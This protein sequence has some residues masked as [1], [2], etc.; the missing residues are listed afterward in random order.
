MAKWAATASRFDLRRLH[1]LVEDARAVAMIGQVAL[2][3]RQ[4][5]LE[6][7]FAM[8]G[9]EHLRQLQRAAGVHDDLHRLDAGELVEEP[10]AAGVHQHGV[11]LHFQQRQ[12]GHG[13]YVGQLGLARVWR[14]KSAG[15]R[16][17]RSSTTLMY[18]SRASQGSRSN[19][20]GFA[21]HSPEPVRRAGNRR[22]RAAERARPG[23]IPACRRCCSRSRGSSGRRR[24]RS[25]TRCSP[26]SQPRGS[27]D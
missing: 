22:R 24:G 6:L 2:R 27:A 25:S 17:L 26:R 21:S 15:C 12:S 18:S 11:A 20:R 13:L 19:S 16:S 8:I 23:S 4:Q 7:S 5:L 9:K 1:P 14:R 3:Q 10:A